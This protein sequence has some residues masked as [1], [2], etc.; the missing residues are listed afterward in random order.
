MADTTNLIAKSDFSTY[1]DVSA[2]IDSSYIDRYILRAQRAHIRGILG[3]TTYQGLQ[4]RKAAAT[5]TADDDA[6]L[7]KIVPVLVYRTVQMWAARA[8]LYHTNMGFR[9]FEEDNSRPATRQ[10]IQNIVADAASQAESWG[11]DLWDFL[12][13]NKDTY[14]DW[15]DATDR[16]KAPGKISRMSKVATRDISDRAT[17]LYDADF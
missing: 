15:R 4:T 11:R 12:T 5:L 6:L 13:T 10:E 8:N 3:D 16:Q 2:Y 1:A 17:R 9:T 14:T 7:A